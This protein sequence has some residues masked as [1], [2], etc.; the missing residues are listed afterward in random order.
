VL[1]PR[2]L[3]KLVPENV[4]DTYSVLRQVINEDGLWHRRQRRGTRFTDNAPL[5]IVLDFIKD[6][7]RTS[8][9][10]LQSFLD[11]LQTCIVDQTNELKTQAMSIMA[12]AFHDAGGSDTE[13]YDTGPSEWINSELNNINEILTNV[14][15]V[16]RRSQAQ[17]R[18]G[19]HAGELLQRHMDRL[20]D[21]V[22]DI[23][24]SA[25][26]GTDEVLELVHEVAGGIMQACEL[27]RDEVFPILWK[28]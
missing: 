17:A 6:Q 4:A 18:S 27:I 21:A 9:Y 20:V 3:A 1:T 22:R 23:Q 28:R 26:E 14:V 5:G 11:H 12:N 2:L 10:D 25:P 15:P 8:R 13:E 16:V 19:K 7:E 24:D